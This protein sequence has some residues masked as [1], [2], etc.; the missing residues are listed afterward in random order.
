VQRARVLLRY[1]FSSTPAAALAR[2]AR[3]S[4][5]HVLARAT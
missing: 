1:R 4:L 5:A 3:R 2:R